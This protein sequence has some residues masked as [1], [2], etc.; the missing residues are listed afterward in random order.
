MLA[1]IR[2]PAHRPREAE[3]VRALTAMPS[4]RGS[5]EAQPLLPCRADLKRP[6]PARVPS[7]KAIV[8]RGGRPLALPPEKGQ[9][10]PYMG[11]KVRR[12]GLA[13]GSRVL[14]PGRTHTPNVN[15]PASVM[16]GCSRPVS[17]ARVTRV[18][19]YVRISM[20]AASATVPA[21]KRRLTMTHPR[22]C[23]DRD[24]CST[25]VVLLEPGAPCRESSR[26]RSRRFSR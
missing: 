23:G 11:Q 25:D 6:S 10:N 15:G 4:H 26:C 14:G 1:H 24:G 13:A 9:R 18:A 19:S 5:L 3:L 12:G 7:R 2:L 8:A 16:A 21:N 22:T 17:M 20:R